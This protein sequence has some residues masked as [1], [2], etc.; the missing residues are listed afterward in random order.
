MW[1]RRCLDASSSIPHE[2]MKVWMDCL[3]KLRRYKFLRHFC[4]SEESLNHLGR[5]EVL[6]GLGVLNRAVVKVQVSKQS[7][8]DFLL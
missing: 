1:A 5:G 4:S 7:D 6:G 8:A 3:M 2:N